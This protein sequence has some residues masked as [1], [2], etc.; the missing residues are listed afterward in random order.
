MCHHLKWSQRLTVSLILGFITRDAK[1]QLLHSKYPLFSNIPLQNDSQLGKVHLPSTETLQSAQL[2]S[3]RS[4]IWFGVISWT[5]KDRTTS[6]VTE[7]SYHV[8]ATTYIW[9]TFKS[10]ELEHLIMA[11]LPFHSLE[12]YQNY[13]FRSF[14][15]AMVCVVV[16]DIENPMLSLWI[17]NIEDAPT[18]N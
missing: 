12:R 13:S 9:I 7:K 18:A 11:L 1:K 3:L 4:R 6:K 8:F 17:E 16:T 2:K 5:S 14:T 10:W 15:L